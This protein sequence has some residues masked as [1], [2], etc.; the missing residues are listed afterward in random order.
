MESKR[1]WLLGEEQAQSENLKKEF[2]LGHCAGVGTFLPKPYVRAAMAARV[3]VLAS[4]YT[5]S[6][7]IAAQKLLELINRNHIPD[8]PS[9]GS[10]GAAGDLAPMAHIAAVVC[11]YIATPTD[12][13]PLDPTPK[14]CVANQ[15]RFTQHLLGS[16]C[17]SRKKG[18][19]R[20]HYRAS[21]TMEAIYAQD[22]C[23]HKKPWRLY[24][25]VQKSV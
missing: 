2:I 21:M 17:R 15:W 13:V 8:V 5:G 20:G 12:F 11:G 7:P 25:S 24:P 6:R 16:Y 4:G 23:I 18:V 1:A 19:G 14:E 10:V 3:N 9:Q 22:Q